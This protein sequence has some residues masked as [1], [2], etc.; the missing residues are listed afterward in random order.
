V[1]VLGLVPQWEVLWVLELETWLVLFFFEVQ[2]LNK[3]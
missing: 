2:L 3:V 1:W